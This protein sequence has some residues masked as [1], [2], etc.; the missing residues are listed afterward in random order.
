[1]IRLMEERD[2]PQ[3]ARLFLKCRRHTF[4]WVD[5]ARFQLEDFEAQTKGEQVWVAEQGGNICGF[6]AIWQPDHFIHH[7][8][9]SNDW[10]GQGIGRAL[11][12]RGLADSPHGALKV[13]I[14]NTAAVAFYHR[15]GWQ[16]SDETGYC[17]VTGPWCKLLRN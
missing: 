7:L 11:L 5:S 9:V 13:A 10:H 6:I 16:N 8:Y 2:I 12:E 3:L 15:L 17:E 14:R 4:H 1:M